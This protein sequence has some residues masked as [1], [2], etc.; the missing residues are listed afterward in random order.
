M[1]YLG[2]LP[3]TSRP[4]RGHMNCSWQGHGIDLPKSFGSACT[5]CQEVQHTSSKATL[6]KPPKTPPPAAGD[7]MFKCLGFRGDILFKQPIPT[8]KHSHYTA[9]H[10]THSHWVYWMGCKKDLIEEQG[11]VTGSMYLK[12]MSCPWP[13]LCTLLCLIMHRKRAMWPPTET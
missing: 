10:V 2:S 6:P 12:G 13:L 9:Q 5:L 7:R 4:R 3:A 11:R 1:E 8:T